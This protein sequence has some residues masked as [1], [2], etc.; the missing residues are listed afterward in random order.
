MRFPSKVSAVG[1]RAGDLVSA[2]TVCFEFPRESGPSSIVRLESRISTDPVSSSAPSDQE[3]LLDS[4]APSRRDIN[5]IFLTRTGQ[6][7]VK[8]INEGSIDRSSVNSWSNFVACVRER[9]P[10]LLL[11]PIH[12]ARVSSAMVTLAETSLTLGRSVTFDPNHE[13]AADHEADILIQ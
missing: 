9:E 5:L 2:A 10:A 7:G 13:K 1:Y 3:R 11:N 6:F 8:S 4:P 12:E